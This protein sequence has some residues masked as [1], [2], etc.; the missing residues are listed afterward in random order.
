MERAE[1]SAE[2]WAAHA[3]KS[4]E[5]GLEQ[6]FNSLRAK[7]PQIPSACFNRCAHVVIQPGTPGPLSAGEMF[8]LMSARNGVESSVL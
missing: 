6:Y 1:P 7:R 4:S 8:G 2:R 5:E 3:R